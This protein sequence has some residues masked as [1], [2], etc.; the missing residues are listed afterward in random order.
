MRK[1]L[2]TEREDSLPKIS[3]KPGAMI[4]IHASSLNGLQRFNEYG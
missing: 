2:A 1:L 4:L 3:L